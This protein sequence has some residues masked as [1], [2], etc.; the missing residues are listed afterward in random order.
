MPGLGTCVVTGA[1]GG[2]GKAVSIELARRGALVVMV[3]RDLARGEAVTRDVAEK[4]G[5]SAVR[6]MVADLSSLDDVRRLARN[7]AADYGRVAALIHTAAVY[8]AERRL[9]GDGLEAMFA[10]NH[11]APYL[12]TRQLLPVLEHDAPARVVV[13]TAPSSSMPD[14]TDLQGVKQFRPLR[15][16]GVSKIG[17]LL[18]AFALARRTDPARITVNAFHPGLMKSDLIREMPAPLRFMI[19]LLARA[20]ERAAR[21]LA[22]LVA[23][24]VVVPNGAFVALNK[25]V[26][27]PKVAARRDLQEEMWR[28]SADLVGLPAD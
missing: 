2:L 12:L 1:S 9:T 4:S 15:A 10:T 19:K 16:F 24:E 3:F 7:I 13:V 5:S 27:P 8:F 17:N 18:F 28:T 20:P 14:F 23:G 6:L 26:K 11:L 22:D 25:V 21:A